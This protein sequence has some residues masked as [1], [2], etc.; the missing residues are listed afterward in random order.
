MPRD[1]C[2]FDAVFGFGGHLHSVR[3]FVI[4]QIPYVLQF[5]EIAAILVRDRL[6]VDFYD[7]SSLILGQ[8]RKA[9]DVETPRQ[10]P[11]QGP[12]GNGYPFHP[13]IGKNNFRPVGTVAEFRGGVGQRFR[14][15]LPS[16]GIAVADTLLHFLRVDGEPVRRAI[17][18]SRGNDH[19]VRE[20]ERGQFANAL[21]S[22]VGT[23]ESGRSHAFH[24]SF[25]V[26]H[27]QEP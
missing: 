22:H 20:G 11:A 25:P 3:Q 10:P 4:P 23:L 2:V 24:D 17:L 26:S 14:V 7:E 8:V 16:C 21:P 6:T 9:E 12:F 5:L 15:V 1:T 18:F 19:L 27:C 13:Q